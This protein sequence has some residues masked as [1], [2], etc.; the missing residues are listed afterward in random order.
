MKIKK[1]IEFDTEF[2][3]NCYLEINNDLEF[4]G[5]MC[6]EEIIQQVAS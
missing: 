3:Q 4:D 6:D 2:L 1:I 5:E